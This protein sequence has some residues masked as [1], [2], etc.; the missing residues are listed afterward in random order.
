MMLAL[1]GAWN[2]FN[3]NNYPFSCGPKYS[4][5]TLEVFR[6]GNHMG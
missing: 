1:D 5:P 4:Q 3:A 2:K 6:G